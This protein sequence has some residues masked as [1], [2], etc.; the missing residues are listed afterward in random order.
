MTQLNEATL[1]ELVGRILGDLGGAVSVPLV[2]IGDVL[3]LYKT[4]KE[5]LSVREMIGAATAGLFVA[6]ATNGAVARMWPYVSTVERLGASF[7]AGVMSGYV[8]VFAIR[9]AEWASEQ[10][11]A[12]VKQKATARFG[13]PPQAV[14]DGRPHDSGGTVTVGPTNQSGPVPRVP[15][16]GT[17]G[18][19]GSAGG[20]SADG[21]D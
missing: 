9:L 10:G 7:V 14:P 3:G 17:P 2:R 18:V 11:L 19:P 5:K 4:L 15:P 8:M 12:W 20:A 1:N 13:T 6:L 16:D 21:A